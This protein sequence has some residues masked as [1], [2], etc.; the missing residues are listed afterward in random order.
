MSRWNT[1]PLLKSDKTH[2][3]LIEII[4][5]Q[6]HRIIKKYGKPT[7]YLFPFFTGTKE[8]Y[9]DPNW[10]R[11]EIKMLCIKSNIK[12][13]T[14]E[15]LQFSWHPLR[16][17]KGTTMAFEGHDILS[18]MMELG[19]T[20]PDMATVYVNNRLNL[21]KQALI[22]KG[23]GHFFDIEGKVDEKIGELLV[24]KN[25]LKATRVCGGACSMPTQIGDW[26]EHANACYTCKYFRADSNDIAFFQAEKKAILNLI[27]LQSSDIKNYQNS[28]HHRLADITLRR[29]NKNREITQNLEVIVEAIKKDRIYI[30]N[31]QK[32]KKVSLL[33]V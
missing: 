4:Q 14:G 18:I 17:T 26:C 23:S 9:I 27:E 1:K 15:P 8:S 33:N 12:D 13:E 6:Q 19:H 5:Q 30:G 20:S 22:E 10:T 24:R 2:Q 29:R 3:F 7:K 25:Q 16:H 11:Y 21:K 28:G 32:S 31:Q